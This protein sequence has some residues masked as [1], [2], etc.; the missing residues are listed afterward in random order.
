MKTCDYKESRKSRLSLI[1]GEGRV[2]VFAFLQACARTPHLNP[3]PFK[4]GEAN[5]RKNIAPTR[6]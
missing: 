2:R 5:Q 6:V 1:K 3:L 4:K